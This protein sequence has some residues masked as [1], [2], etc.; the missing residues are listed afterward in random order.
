M[1]LALIAGAFMSRISGTRLP[2]E[3]QIERR[4]V[5]LT[6]LVMGVWLVLLFR[7]FYLQVVLGERFR[8]SA[9]QNSV[10]THHI[11]A[12][13]GIIFDRNGEI[14]VD[15]R[16][17]FDVL[18]IPHETGDLARALQR[19]GR[20]IGLRAEELHERVGKPAGRARFQ[21]L[22]V[23]RDIGRNAQARVEARLYALP[24][25][26]TQVAPVRDY[27]GGSSAAHV[28]GRLGEIS[29]AQ[30]K[31]RRY[32]DY[33]RGDV[34]GTEGV[35][36]LLDAD[37]RGRD[38]GKNLLVDAHGREL[39]LLGK[40]E[41]Q[42]GKHVVLTLD[43]RLQLEAE[44]ALDETDNA[45]AVVALDPRNGEVLVLT[46]RPSFDPNLFA[47]GIGW[48]DWSALRT[49]PRTPLHNRAL[50]GQYPPGSTYKVVTAL[51]GL[52]EGVIDDDFRVH[53]AGSFR[54][55]RRRYRCWK[56][57][58]HGDVDLHRALVESCDVFFYTVG[59]EVGVDR[60]AHHASAL[61]L[62]VP[63]GIEL[64]PEAAGLV[65]TRAWKKRRFG[66]RWIEG[67]TVSLAIGQGFNL[68]TP[69]QLASL[70][71]AIGNGGARY[72]PFVV[73]RV[74]DPDGRILRETQP[75]FMGSLPVSAHSL[76][77]VRQGL[78]GAVH[79]PHAT[80]WVMRRLPGGVES[81]GKT[82]T[83]QVVKLAKYPLGK[84]ADIPEALRDHAWFVTY[85][86]A[87]VPRIVIAVLVEHGGHGASAA[88]PIAQRVAATFLANERELHAR[89]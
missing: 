85:V 83:A 76:E 50:Q 55:G 10:R 62:G 79:D 24:G 16:P 25:V 86:P 35:E 20:L 57:A 14:L 8:I 1:D 26:I 48:D 52:E 45:G 37:V 80:G 30:L 42:P 34:I 84:D 74:T 51:A 53:C 71:G 12:T 64:G 6:V 33:R 61:G 68:W 27:R 11:K 67:E 36:R 72:R 4:L 5:T 29:L 7:L 78:H 49:D 19:I 66:E 13:R 47:V 87:Q 38:G 21:T 54:L 56:R 39:E 89:H 2:V 43:R 9:S 75:Q 46:S 3:G 60:I 15:S 81:A 58:G 70:Y 17:S 40:I 63:T 23:A 44:A 69:I 22:E 88:A 59:V 82:G 32:Q 28:L 73:K 18:V 65:P 77:Q 31:S 41:P